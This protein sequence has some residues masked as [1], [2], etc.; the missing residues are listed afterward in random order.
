MFLIKLANRT[1]TTITHGFAHS[2]AQFQKPSGYM[3]REF[4]V[5]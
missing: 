2:P 4:P 3:S 1:T 5:W